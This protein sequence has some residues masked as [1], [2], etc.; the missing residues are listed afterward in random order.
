MTW[1]S[2]FTLSRKTQTRRRSSRSSRPLQIESLEERQLLSSSI[3]P[4]PDPA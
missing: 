3:G 1:L 2:L 4:L